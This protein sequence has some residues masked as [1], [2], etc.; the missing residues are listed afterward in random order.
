[1]KKVSLLFLGIIL[2]LYSCNTNEDPTPLD[3]QEQTPDDLVQA[4]GPDVQ[5][6]KRCDD[7]KIQTIFLAGHYSKNWQV[8]KYLLNGEDVTTLLFG[9]CSLDNVQTFYADGR[10]IE[11]EGLTKCN[12]SDPDIFDQGPYN[13]N[14]NCTQFNLVSSHLVVN[15]DIVELSPNRFRIKFVDPVLGEVQLWLVPQHKGHLAGGHPVNHHVS[16]KLS[17]REVV[18]RLKEISPFN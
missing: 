12:P 1:M 14:N 4:N 3:Q 10:Y 16:S 6:R 17:D 18:N 9:E 2:A 13:F 11:T 7:C 8:V 5:A 15:F